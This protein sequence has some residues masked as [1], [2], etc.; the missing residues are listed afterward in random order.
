MKHCCKPVVLCALMLGL[1]TGPLFGRQGRILRAYEPRPRS[2]ETH[3]YDRV[4]ASSVGIDSCNWAA[5]MAGRRH[6]TGADDLQIARLRSNALRSCCATC[7]VTRLMCLSRYVCA[8]A[9]KYQTFIYLVLES[10]SNS[11][12]RQGLSSKVDSGRID[13]LVVL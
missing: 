1:P 12:R 6:P 10:T 8:L 11:W 2:R 4:C 9:H 3:I 5:S 7:S 13:L